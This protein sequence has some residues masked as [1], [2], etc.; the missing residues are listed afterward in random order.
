MCLTNLIM[1]IFEL[2]NQN[3]INS[4]NLNVASNNE[5]SSIV[6]SSY[7]ID[8]EKRE[9]IKEYYFGSFAIDSFNSVL[10]N[11]LLSNEN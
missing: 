4:V 9:R 11:V 5:I 1:I 2:A 10:Q 6:N 3:L 8:I 7:N